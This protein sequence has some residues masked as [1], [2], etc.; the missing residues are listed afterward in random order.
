MEMNKMYVILFRFKLFII[1]YKLINFVFHGMEG[2]GTHTY[3]WK[4][5]K[6]SSLYLF[7]GN[8]YVFRFKLFMIIYIF[9]WN[10]CCS[11]FN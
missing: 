9:S 2:E 6:I 10:V 1:N 5:K 11:N 7:H 3:S 4:Q 8:E